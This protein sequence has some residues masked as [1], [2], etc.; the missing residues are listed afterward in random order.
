MDNEPAKRLYDDILA[1]PGRKIVTIAT[2]AGPF[3]FDIDEHG[4]V[5][6]D[7]V[8]EQVLLGTLQIA[9]VQAGGVIVRTFTALKIDV[10]TPKGRMP[11]PV[12]RIYGAVTG[13]GNY[14]WQTAA[15]TKAASE[16]D[17]TTGERLPPEP[18]VS[19][20]AYPKVSGASDA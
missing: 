1:I 10:R 4:N 13:S 20:C 3:E 11:L 2:F 14:R 6:Y 5:G 19:Y 8:H 9:L 15:E 18:A 7:P 12:K 17:A 16:T